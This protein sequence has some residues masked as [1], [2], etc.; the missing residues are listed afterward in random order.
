MTLEIRKIV[1]FE[2]E[3]LVEGFKAADTPLRM[4]AVA[5]VIKNPWAGKYV[6]D[7]K[8]IVLEYGPQLGKLLTDRICELAGGADKIEAFGKAALVGLNGE[9]EHASALIHT[10]HFGNFYREAVEAKSFLSFTNTRGPANASISVPMMDK[11]DGGKRSHYLTLQFNINDAPGA[12]EV[13]V[14]LGGATGGRPHHRIGDRYQELKELGHDI[15]NPAA[16]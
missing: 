13:V 6:E 2:E 3:T 14:V 8:P 7:L 15:E 1:S 10:L 9:I 16:V 5:A 12:D 4:F 11:N